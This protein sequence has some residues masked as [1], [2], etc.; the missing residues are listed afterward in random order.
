[1]QIG[2]NAPTTG[3]LIEPDSLVR[4][5][6]EGEA[7]GFDYVT[8]SDHIMVPRNLESKYPY[9]DSGEFPAGAGGVAG[10]AHTTAY[11]AGADQEAAL[12]AVG[13]GGAAS[14]RRADREGAVHHRLSLQGPAD[15]G[16]RGWLVPR[17]VRGDRRRPVRRSRR[18]DGRMD[19]G[20][21]G[22]L[23]R[24]GAEIRW[25]VCEVR[26]CGVHAQAGAAAD[27]DLGRR[28]KRA[29]APSHRA[30][31]PGLVS[32]RHEPAAPDEHGLDLQAG[33]DRF[34]EFCKRGDRDPKEITLAYRVLS[35]PGVRPRG[36]IE[37]EAELFT[38]GDADWVGDIRRF[39]I[40]ASPRSMCGCSA[41][42]RRRPCKA[43]STTCTASAT[44]CCRSSPE[45]RSELLACSVRLRF[46]WPRRTS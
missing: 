16:H 5:I 11:I 17:R 21:P 32:G 7:L 45:A 34:H 22:A 12:R 44:A 23:V 37:G 36:S 15:P 24:R 30:L 9:T 38:G 41:M 8:I 43:R 20:V 14:P 26:R 46:R 29:G 18:R 4:I 3:P 42:A 13:H 6:T 27:S 25:Q 28:G 10:T 19:G 1:M 2:F 35:G 33:L 31:C 39:R 40:S